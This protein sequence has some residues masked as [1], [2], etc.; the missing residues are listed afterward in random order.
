MPNTTQESLRGEIIE[1]LRGKSE[2]INDSLW[3]VNPA[4]VDSLINTLLDRVEGIVPD[5]KPIEL[6]HGTLPWPI[7]KEHNDLRKEMLTRLSVLRK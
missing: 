2:V 6:Y 1:E 7:G 4:D 3:Y 5:E